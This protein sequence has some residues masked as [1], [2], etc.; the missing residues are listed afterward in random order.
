MDRRELETAAA[1][2]TY[3]R[4]LTALPLG[5][6]FVLTGVGNLG[7]RPLGNPFAFGASL[8]VLALAYAGIVRYYNERYG[9]VRLTKRS[10]VRFTV[11]SFAC[12]GIGLVG[13]S[14]LDFR[15]DVPISLFAVTFGAAMLLWSATCVGLRREHLLVWGALIIVGLLPLWGNLHDRASAGWLPVGVAT[16]VAGILDHRALA[17]TFG[18][19]AELRARS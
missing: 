7:W 11:V 9:R 1:R 8:V 14:T 15:L 18:P 13:G 5:L 6:L 16:V 2:S 12:F 10:E 17:R 3:L 19:A 4:G